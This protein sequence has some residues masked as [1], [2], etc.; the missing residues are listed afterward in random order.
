MIL[1]RIAEP[2][3]NYDTRAP[4]ILACAI[5]MIVITTLAVILRFWSRAVVSNLEF[6]WDDWALLATMVSSISTISLSPPSFQVP[7]FKPLL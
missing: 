2:P 1:A 7:A 4:E 3:P 6:W 5:I